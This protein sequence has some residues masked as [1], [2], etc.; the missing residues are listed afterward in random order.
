MK[1][2]ASLAALIAALLLLSSCG[3]NSI[4][5]QLYSDSVSQPQ[6]QAAVTDVIVDS[7]QQSTGTNR[8]FG[9]PKP[10]EIGSKTE[11][12]ATVTAHNADGSI[13]YAEKRDALGKLSSEYAY[14]GYDDTLLFQ[15]DY[16]YATNGTLSDKTAIA[17]ADKAF[18]Y[19]G[20][21][22]GKTTAC[23][24]VYTSYDNGRESFVFYRDYAGNEVALIQRTYNADGTYIGR[25]YEYGNLVYV[26]TYAA[27]GSVLYTGEGNPV[28]AGTAISFGGTM[29][30]GTVTQVYENGDF[31]VLFNDQKH[32]M[33]DGTEYLD[34]DMYILFSA[35]YK[36]L[37]TVYQSGDTKICEYQATYA[38]DRSYQQLYYE[39]GNLVCTLHYDATDKLV[40]VTAADGS[41]Y[42]ANAVLSPAI[43]DRIGDGIVCQLNEDGSFV[44]AYFNRPYTTLSGNV[45]EGTTMYSFYTAENVLQ[46]NKY[47]Y[48]GTGIAEYNL[49][50]KDNGAYSVN[51]F[52]NGNFML[53]VEYDKN[54]NA[55][56]ATDANGNQMQ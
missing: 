19:V 49:Y 5:E 4:R 54:G 33:A 20:Q 51:I 44:V 7:P 35:Q 11:Q 8:W 9:N 36:P 21:T 25:F 26:R 12:G 17:L 30:N 53:T 55:V 28:T 46:G 3:G 13:Y 48:D 23:Q 43:G 45:I 10:A 41:D 24:Q 22:D 38:A 40:R 39:F 50:Y 2:T 15:T 14:S 29:V 32:K 52:E 18:G 37:V 16:R 27:D 34:L 56:R 47:F 1:K 42:D 31:M 6:S